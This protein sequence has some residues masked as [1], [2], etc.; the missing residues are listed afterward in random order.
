M[1]DEQRAAAREIYLA[2]LP[3]SFW[4]DFGDFKPFKLEMVVGN[5]NGG[6]GKAGEG[7]SRVCRIGEK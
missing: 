1:P 3:E 7:R 4:I 6:F 5:Y 2:R